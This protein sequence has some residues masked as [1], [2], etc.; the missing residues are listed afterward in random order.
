MGI[1][2][3]GQVIVGWAGS[4]ALR[5]DNST[6]GISVI[7]PGGSNNYFAAAANRDGSVVVGMALIGE[8]AEAVY[9]TPTGLVPIGNPTGDVSATA[10][11][12]SADGSVIAGS[13][14]TNGT[15]LAFRWTAST[16]SLDLDLLPGAIGSRP[17]AVSADGS[18]IVGGDTRYGGKD[19]EAFRWTQSTG[20]IGLG[21]LPGDNFS[22][23]NAVNADGSVIVGVSGENSVY[24]AFIWTASTGIISLQDALAAGGIDVSGWKD[25]IATGVSADGHVIVGNGVDPL[26]HS[27]AW[28][29]NLSL[30]GMP[31]GPGR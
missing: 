1:S 2:G 31:I 12:V 17:Y 4:H 23:A 29:A 15:E 22:Q 6:G 14:S 20:S 24:H 26:G 25:L 3:D 28:I 5:W 30:S 13:G 27:E 19:S 21:F 16:G 10:W 7:D 8:T 9:W 11:S 18:V